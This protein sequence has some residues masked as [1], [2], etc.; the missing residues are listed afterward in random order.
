MLNSLY[1]YEVAKLKVAEFLSSLSRGLTPGTFVIRELHS[2]LS[3][4]EC[5][6]HS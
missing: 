4:A 1:A 6:H 3:L 5:Y 2:D